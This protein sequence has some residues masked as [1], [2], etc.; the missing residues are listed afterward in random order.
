[1]KKKIDNNDNIYYTDNLASQT[2]LPEI[3]L[4]KWPKKKIDKKFIIL[5]ANIKNIKTFIISSSLVNE[6]KFN[7]NDMK[8]N[9]IGNIKG[10]RH[11]K[12]LIKIIYLQILSNNNDIYL[13]KLL[14]NIYKKNK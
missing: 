1:M 8:F 6:F 11:Y 10:G 5:N 2:K 4:T 7:L 13:E 14:K 3:F 9:D 12:D